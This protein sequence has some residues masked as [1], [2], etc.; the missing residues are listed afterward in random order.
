M[1]TR[2]NL[3]STSLCASVLFFLI[4]LVPWSAAAGPHDVDVAGASP[5]PDDVI[6]LNV[7]IATNTNIGV[8]NAGATVFWE[9]SSVPPGSTQVVDGD[10]NVTAFTLNGITVTLPAGTPNSVNSTLPATLVGTPVTGGSF[11]FRLQVADETTPAHTRMRTYQIL[12]VQPM[13]VLLVLDRSG[14]M[15]TIISGSTRRWDALKVAASNFANKYQSLNRIT[16]RMGITYFDTDLLPPSACCGGLV[17]V[18]STIATTINNDINANSPDGSTCMGCG[19]KDA[20]GK[21]ADPSRARTI[22]LIT[23]GEQNQD[24]MVKLDGTGYSDGT[25]IP[26]GNTTGSIKIF[27]IGI[28][29]PSG[30]FHTTLQNLALNHRGSY[31]T[32]DDGSTFT[33]DTSSA[34]VGADGSLSSGFTD[35]F[36]AVFT[37]FSPQLIERSS[38]SLSG[39]A[40]HALQSFPLNKQVSKLLLEFTFDKNFEIPTLAQ[41]LARIVVKKGATVVTPK[42]TPS[43]VGNYTNTVLFTFD[44]EGA[45]SSVGP[46]GDWSVQLGDLTNYKVGYCNLTSIADDHRLHILRDFTNKSPKVNDTFPMSVT[47]DWLS[48]PITDATVQAVVLRPGQDWGDFLAN[49]PLTVDVSSAV[50]AGSPGLQKFEKLWATDSAF[51]A[52]LQR[53]QN[54]VSLTHT[55]NGKYDG[56]FSGLTVAGV[57]RIMFLISGTNAEAGKYKRLLSESFYTSF[58]SVDMAQSAVSVQSV[59]GGIVMT[60]TPTT[61][62]HKKVG[63]AMGRAFA[64]SDPTITISSVVDHQNGSYTLTFTGGNINDPVTLTLLGQEIYKGKLIDAGKGGSDGT[65]GHSL[66]TTWWFWLLLILVILITWYILKKK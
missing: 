10:G 5:N 53:T 25:S 35:Q 27:T 29:S 9:F 43:W 1:K 44:F 32:T 17:A 8:L 19:L 48:Y 4:C 31:N 58:S 60:I 40:P 41:V 45:A 52:Q 30:D 42:A 65:T 47:L 7:G 64:V 23:D 26:G 11:S 66:F 57:Y 18:N 13:D 6:Q 39:A 59:G 56:T 24:P 28:G 55:A 36:M 12:V 16:D 46:E 14:S 51:R 61:S 38:T 22:L 37:T 62:Y 3:F 15:G 33:F 34:S 20:Q 54:L 63:P 49:Y 21:L 2:P 50:D